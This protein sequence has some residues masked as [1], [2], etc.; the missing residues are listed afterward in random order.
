MNLDDG[1]PNFDNYL[2]LLEDAPYQHK[3]KM[4]IIIPALL[5]NFYL[6]QI[7]TLFER[8]IEN[9]ADYIAKR[10]EK[11]IKLKNIKGSFLNQVNNWYKDNVDLNIYADGELEK[12]TQIYKLRNTIVHQL[13]NTYGM[14]QQEI[15]GLSNI[16]ASEPKLEMN[17]GFLI[18]KH[19][20][21]EN[22]LCFIESIL[23]RIVDCLKEKYEKQEEHY[24]LIQQLNA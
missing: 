17:E 19:G 10:E 20:Y 4:E 1:D 18:V 16:V 14:N 23:A 5:R 3:Y 2:A 7:Y 6:V 22:S 12:L 15:N 21:L 24:K 13:S 8:W 9:I 11:K